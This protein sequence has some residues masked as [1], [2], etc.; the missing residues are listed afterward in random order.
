M[1]TSQMMKAQCKNQSTVWKE[2][3]HKAFPLFSRKGIFIKMLKVNDEKQ[4]K[5]YKKK[6]SS[7]HRSIRQPR[8]NSKFNMRVGKEKKEFLIKLLPFEFVS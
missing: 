7:S 4:P 3:T 5:A 8:E 1:K 6:I 2:Q